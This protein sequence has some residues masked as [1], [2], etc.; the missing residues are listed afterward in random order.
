MRGIEIPEQIEQVL[1]VNLTGTLIQQN[2]RRDGLRFVEA[3]EVPEVRL[4]LHGMSEARLAS[5]RLP[6]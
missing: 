4:R 3:D 6:R 1:D 5:D 2:V